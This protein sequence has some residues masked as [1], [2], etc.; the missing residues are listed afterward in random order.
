MVALEKSHG[1]HFF[2]YSGIFVQLKGC[3]A[4]QWWLWKRKRNHRWAKW[5]WGGLEGRKRQYRQRL[6]PEG[7]APCERLV[8]G[9]LPNEGS[10]GCEADGR[11][12]WSSCQPNSRNRQRSMGCQLKVMRTQSMRAVFNFIFS[13]YKINSG[14]DLNVLLQILKELCHNPA[15]FA[16]TRIKVCWFSSMQGSKQK[17]S[18]S[19]SFPGGAP[20]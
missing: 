20:A 19:S 18:K 6:L 11:G 8:W 2:L 15:G 3:S 5:S 14:H 1:V 17:I 4:E 10:A 12:G 16:N 9:M 7:R 13:E